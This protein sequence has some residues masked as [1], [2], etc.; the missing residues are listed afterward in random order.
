MLCIHQLP[1]ESGWAGGNIAS[2]EY[3]GDNRT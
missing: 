1:R 3:L 2:W